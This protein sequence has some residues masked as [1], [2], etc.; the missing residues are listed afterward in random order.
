MCTNYTPTARDR[1]LAT[2]LGLAGV[3]ESAWPLEV[4]PG[5]EAP[6]VVRATNTVDAAHGP[7]QTQ[8]QVAR[9]GLVPRWCKDAAQATDMGR[10]TYNARSET[11]NLKPSFRGPW[12]DRQ[13]ALLPM[14][15]FFEPC[16]EGANADAPATRA[17][18]WRIGRADASPF[19][20]AGLWERWKNPA[21]GAWVHSMTL[22]TVNADAHP[23]MGRM[24]R[25]GEEKRMPLIISEHHYADW[26][27]ASPNDAR[28]L[29]NLAANDDLVG[30]PAPLPPRATAA[31][32]RLTGAN[33]KNRSPG[34]ADPFNGTLPLF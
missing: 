20:A 16:W 34:S 29:M 1:L 6:I 13:W 23:L 26:L 9:F 12:H 17:T 11:A 32:T 22:L 14:A 21:S 15:H 4:F 25:P 30:E 24:H 18:R 10:K 19:A 28:E 8:L 27:H 5:Y 33:D 31:R 7:L 2:R 3:S